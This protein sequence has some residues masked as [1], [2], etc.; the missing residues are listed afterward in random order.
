ME[1]RVWEK[2]DS[3]DE[4][5]RASAFFGGNPPMPV[6]TVL[7]PVQ[8]MKQYLEGSRRGHSGQ[9]L[10]IIKI[11]LEILSMS[12]YREKSPKTYPYV[13]GNLP[14]QKNSFLGQRHTLFR[15]R[16]VEVGVSPKGLKKVTYP[17][18]VQFLPLDDRDHPLYIGATFIIYLA[19]LLNQFQ[20]VRFTS[21]YLS[22]YHI[23]LSL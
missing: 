21:L 22:D 15:K 17:W 11:I 18:P 12:E 1:L 20:V 23:N 10:V 14:S 9:F 2:G 16:G 5:R 7:Q 13:F 6:C 19:R 8:V 4:A 3:W